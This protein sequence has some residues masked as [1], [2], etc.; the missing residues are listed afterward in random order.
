MICSIS[1]FT[2]GRIKKETN[3]SKKRYNL[4]VESN[5]MAVAKCIFTKKRANRRTLRMCPQIFL[6]HMSKIPNYALFDWSISCSA[7]NDQN[8]LFIS[9]NFNRALLTVSVF[10][11]LPTLQRHHL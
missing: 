3:S 2:P 5:R 11:S 7:T 10:R 6:S 8:C 9:K 4:L 1:I